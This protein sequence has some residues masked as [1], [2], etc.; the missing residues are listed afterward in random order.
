MSLPPEE[1]APEKPQMRPNVSFVEKLALVCSELGIAS[2]QAI[3][4]ALREC[5]AALGIKGTG[6]L[7]K[8]LDLLS[9]SLELQF[10][11]QTAVSSPAS[12]QATA[13]HHVAAELSIPIPIAGGAMDDV[14]T[15]AGPVGASDIVPL[16]P[17]TD[18]ASACPC[19]LQSSDSVARIAHT[20]VAGV[21]DCPLRRE[22]R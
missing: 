16:V 18:N 3:P 2:E 1:P 8:Q 15:E 6:P 5:N 12:S 9:A 22:E 4:T 13:A 21:A 10:G 14:L 7:M 17:E 20:G 11:L 19:P